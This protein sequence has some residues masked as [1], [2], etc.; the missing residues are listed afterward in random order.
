[1]GKIDINLD[2]NS[3]SIYIENGLLD[4]IGSKIKQIYEGKKIAVVTDENVNNYYGNKILNKLTKEDYEVKMI[5]F[6]SGERT[7]S[8]EE[9]VKLYNDFLDFELTRS[10]LVAAFGGGVIG[11]L[12]GFAA[13]TFL[14]GISFVQIPTSMLAQIDSSIGG[15]T[16][17]NL[18]RGKNLIG[19]FYQPKAVFIDP[20][21]L[22]TL[23]KRFLYDGMAEVIK[24]GAINDK[25]LF[26]NLM[27]YEDE[28]ELFNNIE[29]IIETC[30]NIKKYYV[31]NDEKDTGQRMILNFG[32]TIGH[33]VEK[34][35]NYEKYTHGEAV[36]I[37]MYTIA[38]KSELLGL[39]A[40]GT[41]EKLKNILIKYKLPFEIDIKDKKSIMESIYLDK[42]SSGKNINLI[43]LD[44]IGK[45]F[46]K[47]IDKAKI[48]E[49]I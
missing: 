44:E 15:K 1:M 36:A 25:N 37:G 46:I 35:F 31:E 18:S 38:Y 42:K 27:S 7:K 40:R 5:V 24:Y 30:C 23:D 41:S 14:R 6:P 26:Y 8:I 21:L 22:K 9:L 16:A 17:V 33:A 32:H 3:Y 39:T 43:L 29:Y 2:K 48:N 13:A 12:T 34:Y 10:D 11:D 20:M 49:F 45:S 4:Y 28:Q 47:T 19:S